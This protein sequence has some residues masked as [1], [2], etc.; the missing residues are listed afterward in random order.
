MGLGIGL[1][2]DWLSGRY[3]GLVHVAIIREGMKQES[4]ERRISKRRRTA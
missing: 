3:A 4:R 1:G 2:K